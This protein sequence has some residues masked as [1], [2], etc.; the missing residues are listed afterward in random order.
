V[1][2]LAA[3]ARRIAEG[4]RDPLARREMLA[5]AA[6]YERLAGHAALAFEQSTKSDKDRE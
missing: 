3:E 5:I 6:S 2:G 1:V 4:M